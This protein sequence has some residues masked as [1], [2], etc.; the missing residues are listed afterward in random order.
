MTPT[1][2]TSSLSGGFHTTSWTLVQH[3]TGNSI[4][5]KKA[6]SELCAACYEPVIAY[7][8]RS[9]R[10]EDTA[11]DIAHGFFEAI[12]QKPSLGGAEPG[13]GRFRNYLLGALKHYLSNKREREGRKMRGGGLE[14]VTLSA[15]TDTSPGVE[16]SDMNSLPPD[17]EFDRQWALHILRSATTA[18]EAEWRGAGK[19]EEFTDLQPFIGGGSEHGDLASLAAS[20]G[21]SA[22]TLRKTLSRMRQRFRQHV[23]NFITPTISENC[24]TDEEMRT[25][26]EALIG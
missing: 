8:R 25:L 23:K 2:T 15:G 1:T 26:F 21:E 19:A 12:L 13:R 17:R 22:A 7:L 18:L 3:A 5:G 6:L 16:P 10:D 11:R 20:R 4:E 24:N 9:G 14:F